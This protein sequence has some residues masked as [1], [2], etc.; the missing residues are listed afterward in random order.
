MWVSESQTSTGAKQ[1]DTTLPSP[2]VTTTVHLGGTQS[3]FS[4]SLAFKSNTNKYNVI[5]QLYLQENLIF[6][7]G[8]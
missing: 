8:G 6:K 2:T 3:V 7:K 1:A 5:C 4:F